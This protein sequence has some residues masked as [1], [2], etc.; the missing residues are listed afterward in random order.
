MSKIRNLISLAVF[1]GVAAIA[2]SSTV[3]FAGESACAQTYQQC[4]SG[5]IASGVSPDVAAT[6]C[7]QQVNSPTACIDRL[8]YVTARA[9]S[10]PTSANEWR[11]NQTYGPTDG[12]AMRSAGCRLVGFAG[13][14]GWRCPSQE[15]RFQVMTA[16]DAQASC[17]ATGT[18]SGT[19]TTT[20]PGTTTP[21]ATGTTTTPR[22]GT[23]TPPTTSSATSTP[24]TAPR[25]GTTATPTTTAASTAILSRSG[26]INTP[27]QIRPYGF[28]AQAR[29]SLRIYVSPVAGSTVDPTITLLDTNGN[30]LAINDDAVY[31]NLSSEI[32][33]IA[34]A[35]GEYTL[36][37]EGLGGTIGNYTVLI[38]RL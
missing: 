33:F 38:E 15:M 28:D 18:T 5:L 23:T 16:T 4:V 1:S 31:G 29:Q 14:D 25:P 30:T 8:M 36:V 17:T 24:G 3:L 37:V 19:T 11:F 22:P 34:P 2:S 26:S 21:P 9:N 12:S 13:L 20:L 7:N 32:L 35:T 10:G 6:Q 27:G